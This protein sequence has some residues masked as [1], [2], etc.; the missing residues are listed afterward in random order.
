MASR[1][2]FGR[3]TSLVR[4]A[5]RAVLGTREQNC[6]PEVGLPAELGSGG[7]RLYLPDRGALGGI[8]TS[9][10]NAAHCG[11]ASSPLARVR[12]ARRWRNLGRIPAPGRAY[13]RML[14]LAPYGRDFA[15]SAAANRVSSK[16]SE[17]TVQSRH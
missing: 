16:G 9:S 14:D 12:I 10:P 11:V 8:G 1:C 5:R 2:S 13:L 7:A 15:A 3:K 17:V 4:L 6:D